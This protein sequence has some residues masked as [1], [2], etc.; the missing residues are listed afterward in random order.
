MTDG[1]NTNSDTFVLTVNSVN[2]APIIQPPVLLFAENF[3][4]VVAPALPVNW[5]AATWQTATNST[6]SAPNSAFSSGASVIGAALLT[7]PSFFIPS[8]TAQLA[9][10][11]SFNSD[12][13]CGGGVLE[14][15]ISLGAFVEI[16]Q[17]GG[18]FVT[19]GYNNGNLWRG[20]S[21]G[22]IT[23]IVNLPSSAAGQN[24]R[25]RW[26]FTALSAVWFVDSVAVT[27]GFLSNVIL[28]EDVSSTNTFA[29]SDLETPAGLL[30]LTATSSNPALIPDGN[31]IF[32][33]TNSPRTMII[34]PATNQFGTATVTLSLSDG[35]TN[36]TRSI[37]VTVNPV[38][39][40]PVFVPVGDRI[41]NEETLLLITN[42]VIDLDNSTNVTTFGLISAPPTAGLGSL[43]GIFSWMPTESQGP[44]LFTVSI[45]ATDNATP[46]QSS[47][48]T[49]NILVR[50]VNLAPTLATVSA[51]IVHVGESLS[52]TNSANDSDLPA[53]SLTFSLLSPPE[54]ATV[55]STSGKFTWTPTE[56]DL[57]TNF[58]TVQVA[59]NGFPNLN[60]QQ[61]ALVEVV[62]APA[63]LSAN[64]SENLFTITWG[65][66]VGKKYRVQSKLTLDDADWIDL[67]GDIVASSSI[68]TKSETITLE[69]QRFYRV[70]LVQ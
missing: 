38:N 50:E 36:T 3:D 53:N 70:I 52:F 28:N 66:I 56:T 16:T 1:F 22:F 26:R 46:S 32:S 21:A 61:S 4:G 39:D 15:S 67:P 63:I 11:H 41:V 65:A 68:E 43:S 17:A 44:G 59:D 60:H 27:D 34:R 10:R 40:A 55:H 20:D 69:G 45:R 33:G 57:G 31:I 13:C 47:T 5:S 37:F 25:L 23:T 51:R 58:I 62:S 64:L 7:S 8:V 48:Q 9:F 19:N 12:V 30:T 14:I 54:N 35:E 24:I 18:S 42:A 2:D 49:F 6:E 29:I